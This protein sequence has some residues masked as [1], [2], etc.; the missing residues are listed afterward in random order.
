MGVSM[1]LAGGLSRAAIN[2]PD[3]KAQ[4]G[5][6]AASFTFIFTAGFGATWLTIPWLYPAEIFPLQIRAKGNAW[7]VVGWCIGNGWTVSLPPPSKDSFLPLPP[8]PT[9][10]QNQPTNHN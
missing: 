5:A 7:G 6:A 9:F 10:P 2:N 3:H 1:F 4:F 8:K